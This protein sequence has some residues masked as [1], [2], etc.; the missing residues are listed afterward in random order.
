[1]W[2][3]LVMLHHVEKWPRYQTIY[4]HLQTLKL[5]IPSVRKRGPFPKQPVF[6]KTP[7]Q[8]PENIFKH[9]YDT[10]PPISLDIERFHTMAKAHVPFKKSKLITNEKQQIKLG[11]SESVAPF[12]PVIK[13]E[14]PE[15]EAPVW[16]E[17]MIRLQ[18]V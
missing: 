11:S 16:A 18:Q 10:A 1:M 13:K 8:L 9:M 7:H 5:E 6:P 12:A 15:G 2:L 4:N 3:A 17:K 14:E